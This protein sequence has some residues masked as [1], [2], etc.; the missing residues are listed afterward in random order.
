MSRNTAAKGRADRGSIACSID[1]AACGSNPKRSSSAHSSAFAAGSGSSTSTLR[2]GSVGEASAW[3]LARRAR[4]AAAR[5]AAL[6]VLRSAAGEAGSGR[7][8][9]GTAG[10]ATTSS[11]V[12]SSRTSGSG[13]LSVAAAA[14]SRAV[15]RS[16]VRRMRRGSI[17]RGRCEAA[18]AGADVPMNTDCATRPDWTTPLTA[19]GESASTITKS[20]SASAATTA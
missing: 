14:G 20:A 12:G 13:N 17:G 1:P 11:S 2:S 8:A 19:G 3:A 6:A 5:A 15:S 7:A 4:R 10:S 9:V 18:S 16:S